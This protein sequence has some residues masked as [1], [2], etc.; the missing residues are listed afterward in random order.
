MPAADVQAA[1]GG[2][3]DQQPNRMRR[4]LVRSGDPGDDCQRERQASDRSAAPP[5]M[6]VR[7]SRTGILFSG[8][9]AFRRRILHVL[10]NHFDF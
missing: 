10:I 4:V 2:E 3:A 1:P 5:R 9:A 6:H 7:R 8:T